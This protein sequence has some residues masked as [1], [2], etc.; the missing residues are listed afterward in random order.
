MSDTQ[1]TTIPAIELRRTYDAPRERVF[2]AWTQPAIAQ[3]FLGPGD[4]KAIDVQMDV[5]VG[6]SYQITMLS[7]EM[8]E[9][10]VSG[11]YREVRAPERLVM[12]WRWHEDDP[13]DEHESLL[14]LEFHDRSGKTELVLRHDQFAALAS[15]N[16]HEGG[17]TRILDRLSSVL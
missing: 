7:P 16:N 6:G 14:T 12:T 9:M 11:I 17:W 10:I 15:R 4:V 1:T 2:A 13:A 5:R 8:G 3:R